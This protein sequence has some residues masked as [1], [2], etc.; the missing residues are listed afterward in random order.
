M[1]CKRLLL[2]ARRFMRER[3]FNAGASEICTIVTQTVLFKMQKKV[4]ECFH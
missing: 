2:R 1:I 3:H 4:K